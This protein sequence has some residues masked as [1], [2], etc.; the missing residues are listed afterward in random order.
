MQYYIAQIA[1]QIPKSEVQKSIGFDNSFILPIIITAVLTNLG[2]FG[3]QLLIHKLSL[4]REDQKREDNANQKFAEGVAMMDLGSKLSVLVTKSEFREE[5]SKLATKEDLK[6]F[7]TKDDLARV[8]TKVGSLETKV[9]SL[10]TK[11]G[12]LETKV[13]ATNT[14]IDNLTQ[15]LSNLPFASLLFHKDR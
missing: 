15:A 11:V 2:A 8:E 6:A 3:I 4:K 10:E 12:S 5:I 1:T 13:D 14:K 9:G 7:T